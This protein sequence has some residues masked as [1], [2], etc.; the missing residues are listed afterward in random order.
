MKM[1]FNHDQLVKFA[2]KR[3]QFVNSMPTDTIDMT[4]KGVLLSKWKHVREGTIRA[5]RWDNI[6]VVR[7][8]R[9]QLVMAKR[10]FRMGPLMG[11]DVGA[12]WEQFRCEMW[13]RPYDTDGN[14]DGWITVSGGSRNEHAWHLDREGTLH[15]SNGVIVRIED[16]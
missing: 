7:L 9:A 2:D 3:K 4:K 14:N 8:N 6:R 1:R 12:S 10:V 16:A 13:Y 11:I 5:R 15:G